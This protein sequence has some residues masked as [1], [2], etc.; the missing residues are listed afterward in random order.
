MNIMKGKFNIARVMIDL[1]DATKEQIQEFLNDE[2]FAGDPIAIMPDAHKG[3]GSCIGFTM[4]VGKCILPEIIGVD[5]GCSVQARNYG[6]IDVDLVEFDKHVRNVVPMGFKIHDTPIADYSGNIPYFVDRD[7]AL[8][9]IGTLGGGNH[10]I[11]AGRD[12]DNNFWVTVHT[13]SRKLG[14]DVAKHHTEVA[15]MLADKYMMRTPC[16]PRDTVEF[17]DYMIDMHNACRY[18]LANRN[19]IHNLIGWTTPLEIIDTVHNYIDA[20]MV[21]R[22]GAVDASE[23]QILLIPFNMRDGI[24]ICVG[25]GNAEWN[26][27]APHGAGRILS[28]TKAKDSLSVDAF[29]DTMKNAGVYTT[30]ANAA[31]LDE[32]PDAYKDKECIIK[33]IEPTVD[34][35]NY[36]TPVYNCKGGN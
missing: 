25:K 12:K 34:I 20:N 7:R 18:A 10:F 8:R 9:S 15:T 29:V 5:I 11:E 24:A 19:A 16:L 14:L 36:I 4:P 28:R 13:G 26:N 2:R 1:D 17:A 22:K 35:I 3:M 32:A 6:N 31:T 33:A 30:T 21:I 27:S 23:G